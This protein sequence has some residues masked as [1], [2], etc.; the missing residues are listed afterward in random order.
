MRCS[1]CELYN[2]TRASWTSDA[3]RFTPQWSSGATLVRL[4]PQESRSFTEF[5]LLLCN[6]R[7]YSRKA[8]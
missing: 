1:E 8:K 4:A 2:N 7:R 6:V 3:G 5:L